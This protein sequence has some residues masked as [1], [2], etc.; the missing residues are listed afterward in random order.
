MR[1]SDEAYRQDGVRLTSLENPYS[2]VNMPPN[3]SSQQ[4]DPRFVPTLNPAMNLATGVPYGMVSNSY[5]DNM[6]NMPMAYDRGVF[7]YSMPIT[8]INMQAGGFPPMGPY[9]GY[10]GMRP[11]VPVQ[12]LDR[13]AI[14]SYPQ[15]YFGNAQEKAPEALS[16]HAPAA[17]LPSSSQPQLPPAEGPTPAVQKEPVVK[18]EPAAS[19]PSESSGAVNYAKP[20][21]AES[22]PAPSQVSDSAK[23]LQEKTTDLQLAS[24]L[25]QIKGKG[26]DLQGKPMSAAPLIPPSQMASMPLS[27]LPEDK[28]PR[29]GESLD[30]ASQRP[31][32]PNIYTSY[33]SSALSKRPYPLPTTSAPYPPFAAQSAASAPSHPPI[34]SPA[35]VHRSAQPAAVGDYYVY[36]TVCRHG[37]PINVHKPIPDVFKCS[38]CGFSCALDK[39]LLSYYVRAV[40]ESDA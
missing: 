34:P 21:P 14:S 22:A 37:T 27:S 7:N 1:R 39:H 5:G 40:G 15:D 32:Y 13:G 12:C 9:Y 35:P 28:R 23:D 18:E 29:I 38:N 26:K 24:I 8:M 2:S 33:A 36:C 20:T 10:Y 6:K 3:I 30:P 4:F 11:G 25:L 16:N 19:K 17:K 31:L